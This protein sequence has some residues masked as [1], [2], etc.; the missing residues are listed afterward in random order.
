MAPGLPSILTVLAIGSGLLGSAVAQDKLAFA[1]YL[2]GTVDPTTNHAVLDIQQAQAAGFDA[3]ALNIG[4]PSAD[5]ALNTTGQLFDF[6]DTVGFKLFFSFDLSEDGTFSDFPSIYTQFSS[7]ESY[8][9]YGDSNLPVVSSFSGGFLGVSPWQSFKDTYNVYLIPN[10]DDDVNYYSDPS[11]FWSSYSS[12][13]DGVFSWDTAWP[14]QDD[15]GPANV[16]SSRDQTVKSGADAAGKAYMMGLSSLQYKHCCGGNWYRS[17]EGTLAQRMQQILDISPQFMEVMT[18]NDGGESHY[19]GNVWPEGA[20]SDELEYGNSTATPHDGWRSVISSFI[21]AF[22]SGAT[23]TDSMVPANSASF[24]GA[25]WYRPVLTSCVSASGS[26]GTPAGWEAGI[27]AVN[28]AVVLPS[29]ASGYSVQVSSASNIIA[30]DT[31][32]GAGLHFNTVSGMVQGA[33][34][35]ELLDS[36]GNVVASASSSV[37]VG[38]SPNSDGFC[39]FNYEVVGL[40]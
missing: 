24:A 13:L 40:S 33:Q 14:E 11:T 17:G 2:I 25:M 26:D 38:D 3:F 10:V 18:W 28:Y 36:S 1:H 5:W 12:A 23:T 31:G 6:A 15:N 4:S 16:S 30:T 29:G 19:I 39:D 22:K 7:R 20:I 27:D 9:T 8:L 34:S 35:V 21:A 32:L 37:D